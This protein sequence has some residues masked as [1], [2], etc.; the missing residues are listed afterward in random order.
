MLREKKASRLAPH[1]CN[2]ME[3]RGGLHLDWIYPNWILVEKLH[4]GVEE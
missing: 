2:Q 4:K 1:I 3:N